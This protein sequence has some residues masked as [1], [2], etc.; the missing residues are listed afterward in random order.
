MIAYYVSILYNYYIAKIKYF[1]K[2]FNW[3]LLAG[4]LNY[5]F[6]LTS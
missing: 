5:A 2:V 6:F 1:Y 4:I 3:C